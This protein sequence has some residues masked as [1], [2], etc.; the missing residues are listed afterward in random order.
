ML[1]EG[2]SNTELIHPVTDRCE[3]LLQSIV[4]NR[5]DL[6]LGERQDEE[7][8]ITLGLLIEKEFVVLV[9]HHVERFGAGGFITKAENDLAVILNISATI[10]DPLF[11]Q[12]P[13][14]LARHGIQTLAD[15]GFHVDF[16]QEVDTTTKV[17]TQLHR[18]GTQALQPTGR[19]GGHIQCNQVFVSKSSLHQGT[20]LQLVFRVG[21]TD[22]SI[23]ILKS[24]AFHLDAPAF[25]HT[26][27]PV[28]HTG[29][30]RGATA[31]AG[32][33]DGV[34]VGEEVGQS[35]DKPDHER[36]QD[37]QVF[38]KRILVQHGIPCSRPSGQT[39]C[40]SQEDSNRPP[41]M[42]G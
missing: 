40:F 20:G 25:Q 10:A 34:V 33:L 38:P 19:G 1:N 16:Q 9:T 37:N 8:F 35:V 6:S 29:I 18:A 3:V 14:D 30:H 13:L 39:W 26:N 12:L 41:G 17:Q 28:E 27:G 36:D 4:L 15:C 31:G 7:E 5:S 32:N 2:L 23:P 42:A 11:P 22:Q 21:E 24:T